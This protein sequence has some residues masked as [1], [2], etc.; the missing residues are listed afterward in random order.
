MVWLATRPLFGRNPD[1]FPVLFFVNHLGTAGAVLLI[2]GQH[3]GVDRID[4]NVT[5]PGR[6]VGQ[7]VRNAPCA[8]IRAVE[9][10]PS[11]F[12]DHRGV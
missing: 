1:P 5:G 11:N 7:A 10:G 3:I 4:G 12:P 9:G 8:V 6:E 2:T